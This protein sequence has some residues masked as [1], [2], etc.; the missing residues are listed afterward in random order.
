MKLTAL[1]IAGTASRRVCGQ[2][3]KETRE[4]ILQD[5]GHRGTLIDQTP[6]HGSVWIPS[7]HLLMA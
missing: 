6:M 4:P 7:Q 1:K 5:C 3:S 2:I